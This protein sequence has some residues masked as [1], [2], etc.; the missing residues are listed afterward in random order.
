MTEFT[1][2][3]IAAHRGHLWSSQLSNA[4]LD[5]IERLQARV[6]SM[7]E[8]INKTEEQLNS[9][10]EL[11]RINHETMHQ[12]I[13]ELEQERRWIPASEIPA[14]MKNGYYLYEDNTGCHMIGLFHFDRSIITDIKAIYSMP[15]LP[16]HLRSRNRPQPPK[17]GE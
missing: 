5:E 13:E 3:F 6:E 2:E 15:L 1:P 11:Y 9:N 16:P 17:D 12:R 8:T 4:A 14:D 10:A 7:Q